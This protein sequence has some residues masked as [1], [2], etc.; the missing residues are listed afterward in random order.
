MIWK[1]VRHVK[2][3]LIKTKINPNNKRLDKNDLF[4]IVNC[5]GITGFATPGFICCSIELNCSTSFL[6]SSKLMTNHKVFS[7]IDEE[8]IGEFVF[9]L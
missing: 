3:H 1:N 5:Y 2:I 9:G 6:H 4:A 7:S 8:S